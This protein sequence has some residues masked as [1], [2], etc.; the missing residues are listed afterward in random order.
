LRFL[1]FGSIIIEVSERIMTAQELIEEMEWA[2]EQN[3][4][5]VEVRF[6][7][8]PKWPFE[9]SI[10]TAVTVEVEDENT[11]EK[12]KVVYLS[13]GTQLGYL[14]ELARSEMGW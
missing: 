7:S 4:G 8:Q 9:Y 10:D 5:D 12:E 13:E 3:K 1:Q 11:D 14:N 6:A 2:I